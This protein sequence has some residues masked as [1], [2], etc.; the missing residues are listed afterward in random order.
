MNKKVEKL[1]ANKIADGK[2]NNLSMIQLRLGITNHKNPIMIVKKI[3]LPI[4][5]VL[6]FSTSCIFLN[7]S[8]I[9]IRYKNKPVDPI[10]ASSSPFP[11][12]ANQY[13][14]I[15]FGVISVVTLFLSILSIYRFYKFIKNM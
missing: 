13:V 9:G 7:I 4:F 14:L 11:F 3:C 8:L 2:Q 12:L 10:A 6:A 5:L 15:A 1:F